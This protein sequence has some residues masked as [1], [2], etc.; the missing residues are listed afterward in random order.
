MMKTIFKNIS[1]LLFAMAMVIASCT[2]EETLNP[3][4]SAVVP[5]D[6]TLVGAS[7]YPDDLIF[8]EGNELSNIESI[9]FSAGDAEVPVV[10]NPALNSDKVVIFN[11]PFD[12]A[13]GSVFGL[14]QII[15][16]NKQ[17]K[18]FTQPFEILQ[19][20]PEITGF[21][22]E[23]PKVG[24][25][26][27]I[28]GNWFQNLVSVI[29]NDSAA[30]YSQLS[31]SEISLKLTA[32][33]MPA[34]VIVTTDAG[35]DT[36]LLD[37]NL[38]YNLYKYNDL[39]GGGKFA[40]NNWYTSG[41][42]AA[43]PVVFSDVDGI[44]GLYV[45][46]LWDGTTTNTWGN[47]ETSAGANPG[48]AETNPDTVFFVA[49]YF[50]VTDTGS[51]FQI[52]ID[53]GISVWACNYT[54]TSEDEIHK[55]VTIKLKLS[56]FGFG[57]DQSNQENGDITPQTITKIKIGINETTTVPTEIRVDNLRFFGYY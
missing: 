7:G 24:T 14:Q 19:P 21:N 36:M 8:I 11:V 28:K 20:E 23:R 56:D 54:F 25:S 33:A 9:I 16:T 37:I 46:I 1:I 35:S 51:S 12:D 55:W 32:S 45:Q 50:C 44:S 57:Y 34:N 22:P 40:T 27:I 15:F 4:I 31:S 52:Q 29:F 47:C 18:S 3:Q 26:V 17:G 13:L 6:S 48:I 2:K 10:F 43:N 38:G 49:D 42:L 5:A 30:D 53:D 41:D 39:D